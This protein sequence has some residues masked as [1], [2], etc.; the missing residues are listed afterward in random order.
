MAAPL[1]LSTSPRVLNR[2]LHR[3]FSLQTTNFRSLLSPY[4]SYHALRPQP[5][6]SGPPLLLVGVRLRPRPT[7]YQLGT[8]LFHSTPRNQGG[9]LIP[10]LASVLKTSTALEFARTAGRIALTFVPLLIFRNHKT[11]RKLQN[12]AANGS[13][14]GNEEGTNALL[15]KI[16]HRTILFRI[17]LSIPFVLFCATLIASLERTPLTG[18]WRMII[19]S[20]D[21]ED[22]IAAQL[23]GPGWYKA[24]G[25]ILSQEGDPQLISTNDWRYVW[26]RDT[27]RR[28]ENTI[29]LLLREGELEPEWLRRGPN[30]VP[31]PP[32]AKYPLRPRP[33]ASEYLHRFCESMSKRIVPPVPHSIPG[34]PYSLLVVDRPD[35]SNAFSYGFGPDGG[36]GV[37]VYS[38]FLDEV[39]SKFKTVPEPQTPKRSWWSSLLGASTPSQPPHHIPTPEETS[40]LAILLSHELAHLILSHHLETLSFG[41]VIVPGVL[42]IATDVFRAVLFPVT[43]MFGPFVNDAVAQIGKVGSGELLKLGEYCGASNQEIE[44]DIVSAR[45]LA[46]AGFDARDAPKFWEDRGIPS[47]MSKD[48]ST[49]DNTVPPRGNND[50]LVRRIMSASHPINELRVS[51]LKKEL[52]RWRAERVAALNKD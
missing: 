34:P 9:P 3:Q 26:V 24:V 17:L 43:M 45:L 52:D 37:V 31:L 4:R 49:S 16:R 33:R 12:S 23:A 11:R 32:P 44:A 7:P 13:E 22:E 36:G 1:R 8:S 42:S 21:E 15:Q 39:L 35:A 38:G 47:K 51:E 48:S 40:Q 2:S 5:P 18:R 20:P 25:E 41:K 6:T 29:P 28:L 27:L 46:Y 14:S 10:I 50:S 19:L 30:D